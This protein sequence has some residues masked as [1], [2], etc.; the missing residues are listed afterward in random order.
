MLGLPVGTY[1]HI[2]YLVNYAS[3]IKLLLHV[4]FFAKK[5]VA[6]C[7]YNVT[8]QNCLGKKMRKL[9]NYASGP[10]CSKGR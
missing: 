9:K 6:S 8:G 7:T 1:G 10:D 3:R 2:Q 4:T 5:I